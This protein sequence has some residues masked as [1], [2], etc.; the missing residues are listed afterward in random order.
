MGAFFLRLGIGVLAF[1]AVLGALLEISREDGGDVRSA[2]NVT[3]RSDPLTA[4]LRR[5]QSLGDAAL[6]DQ[7]CAATWTE[8]RRRFLTPSP[9]S[10]P[11]E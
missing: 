8:T 9:S 10:H 2:P 11:E 1:M 4:E 7:D 6:D 5:C 3:D